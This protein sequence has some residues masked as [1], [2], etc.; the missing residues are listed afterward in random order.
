MQPHTRSIL[1]SVF[2]MLCAVSA[3]AEATWGEWKPLQG[4]QAVGRDAAIEARVIG[5]EISSNGPSNLGTPFAYEIRNIYSE[6]VAKVTLNLPKRDARTNIWSQ[7][8]PIEFTIRPGECIAVQT[9]YSPDP[10]VLNIKSVV[11][12]DDEPGFK[13]EGKTTEEKN[14][15]APIQDGAYS[16]VPLDDFEAVLEHKPE[17]P[18]VLLDVVIAASFVSVPPVNKNI[19]WKPEFLKYLEMSAAMGLIAE[20]ISTEAEEVKFRLNGVFMNVLS[21]IFGGDRQNFRFNDKGHVV[22]LRFVSVSPWIPPGSREEPR[23]RNT[24]SQNSQPFRGNGDLSEEG[25]RGKLVEYT[26]SHPNTNKTPK[27]GAFSA[28]ARASANTSQGYWLDPFDKDSHVDEIDP[29]I[30]VRVNNAAKRVRLSEAKAKYGV[31]S[32]A[33]RDTMTLYSEEAREIL[34]DRGTHRK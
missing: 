23:N 7:G 25:L 30:Y 10:N 27:S 6:H 5:E 26:S 11:H 19:P 9:C 28:P 31:P 8:D 1:L 14:A 24:T 21:M 20:N 12:W 17:G 34:L 32:T 18:P 29:V 13:P 4:H 16:G 15:E 3:S 33:N 2:A 22:K